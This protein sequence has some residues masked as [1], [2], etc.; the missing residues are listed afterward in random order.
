MDDDIDKLFAEIEIENKA[1]DK[2]SNINNDN[3]PSG[4]NKPIGLNDNNNS[5]AANFKLFELITLKRWDKIPNVDKTKMLTEP[6]V[7]ITEYLMTGIMHVPFEMRKQTTPKFFLFR[8]KQEGVFNEL[9]STV[10]FKDEVKGDSYLLCVSVSR[11]M[12]ERSILTGNFL[13]KLNKEF[14]EDKLNDKNNNNN[15][16]NDNNSVFKKTTDVLK[17]MYEKCIFLNFFFDIIQHS[18]AEPLMVIAF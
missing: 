14:N 12:N 15:N 10:I 9:H 5:I 1:F 3:I 18:A 7:K 17:I 16:N 13:F 8:L 2:A 11:R 6:N 4:F